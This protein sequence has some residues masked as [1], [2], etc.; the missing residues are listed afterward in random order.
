MTIETFSSFYR[1]IHGHPP[2]VWQEELLKRVA[3]EGWPAT[4]A[5]PTSS[6]KTSAIDVA[7]FHLALEAVKGAFERRSSLR[8]FFIV[9]RRVV[10]DEAFDHA[11]KIADGLRDAADGVLREVA[12]QLKRFGGELPLQVSKMRGGMLRDNGWAD[13]P[14]Q[15]TVCLS[16]VDQVGSRLLFCG[17]QVGERSR[18]VHAGLIGNDSLLILDEAHLSNAFHQTLLSVTAKYAHWAENYPRNLLR[19]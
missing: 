7:V 1:A 6:G 16:T 15:P 9:D 3:A 13:E 2:F 5:M 19:W 17:Y 10:V 18:S 14:N 11:Q 12:L 4:I 8:T